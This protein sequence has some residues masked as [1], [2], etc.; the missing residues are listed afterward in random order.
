MFWVFV[1]SFLVVPVICVM[2]SAS[3]YPNRYNRPL[4]HNIGFY[5]CVL[6]VFP[7]ITV[8]GID[9]ICILFTTY[10]SWAFI[11]L[12]GVS[13][14]AHIGS[15]I[16]TIRHI[17]DLRKHNGF[18][19]DKDEW[20]MERARAGKRNGFFTIFHW[21][22]AHRGR[23]KNGEVYILPAV[24]VL[25]SKR[26]RDLGVRGVE[27][28]RF[29]GGRTIIRYRPKGDDDILPPKVIEYYKGTD[30]KDIIEVFLPDKYGEFTRGGWM[31]GNKVREFEGF[32]LSS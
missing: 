21:Q 16:L 6:V 26:T 8:L 11:F 25:D 5:Y 32:K 13:G 27:I 18:R 15:I 2:Y 28:E 30:I 3:Q 17:S 14:I 4:F 22:A 1:I 9:W 10:S 20:E 23:I 31:D 24:C 29:S 19:F 7:R 12:L